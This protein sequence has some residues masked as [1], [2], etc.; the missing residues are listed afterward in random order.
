MKKRQVDVYIDTTILYLDAQVCSIFCVGGAIRYDLEV[1]LGL[2]D[3][4]VQENVVPKISPHH[5]CKKAAAVIGRAVLG[6]V[7]IL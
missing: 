1:E 7:L 5:Y 4:Q 3:C 6:L 2:D